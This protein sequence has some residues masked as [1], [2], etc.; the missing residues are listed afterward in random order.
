MNLLCQIPSK[1]I[2]VFEIK[3]TVVIISEN[4][5]VDVQSIFRG[6]AAMSI[7]SVIFHGENDIAATL[8]LLQNAPV[9][10]ID[11]EHQSFQSLI[12]LVKVE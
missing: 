5:T 9:I 6:I 10:V 3:G 12:D 4:E 2:S 7:S 8:N 11:P 1:G